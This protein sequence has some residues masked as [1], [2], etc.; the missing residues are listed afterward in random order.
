MAQRE[1]LARKT[2]EVEEAL[3]GVKAHRKK[4]RSE[5]RFREALA[6]L[7]ERFPGGWP[8]GGPGGGP[9]FVGWGRVEG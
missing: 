1:S 8:E 2:E 3:G 6:Q 5:E 9:R 4:A 7:K